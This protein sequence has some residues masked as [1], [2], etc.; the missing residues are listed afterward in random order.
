MLDGGPPHV[1]GRLARAF[2]V[3]GNFFQVLG[4]QAALGRPLLLDD[5]T[6]FEARPVIVLSYVGWQSCSRGTV[7]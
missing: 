1:D 6:R 5:D 3:T 7:A 2:L 4:V